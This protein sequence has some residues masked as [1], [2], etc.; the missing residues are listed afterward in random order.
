MPLGLLWDDPSQPASTMQYG[1]VERPII[2]S[3]SCATTQRIIMHHQEQLSKATQSLPFF[4]IACNVVPIRQCLTVSYPKYH[5]PCITYVSDPNPTLYYHVASRNLV[6]PS[7]CSTLNVFLSPTHS[8]NITFRI[9]PRNPTQ[10]LLY[11]SSHSLLLFVISRRL[12]IDCMLL[13]G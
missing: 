1:P 12:L 4:I 3:L 9:R 11:P 2:A 6:S 10:D 8:V 7:S 13:F 5:L